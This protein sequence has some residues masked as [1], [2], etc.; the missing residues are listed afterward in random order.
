MVYC[1]LLKRFYYCRQIDVCIFAEFLWSL[2]SVYFG[3]SSRGFARRISH[4]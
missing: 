4:R 2:L 1:E 3:K